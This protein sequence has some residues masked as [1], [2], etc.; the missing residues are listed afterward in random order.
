MFI[1]KHIITGA[2]CQTSLVTEFY[3]GLGTE[4]LLNGYYIRNYLSLIRK[5]SSI[6]LLGIVQLLRPD[7]I[8][9]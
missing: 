5:S 4:V 3:L 7:W 1:N 2:Y 8:G 6:N 9:Q